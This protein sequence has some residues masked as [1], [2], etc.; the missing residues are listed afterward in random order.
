MTK[1]ER[2][3]ARKTYDERNYELMV[4]LWKEELESIPRWNRKENDGFTTIPRWLPIINRIMDKL[5][6]G[7]PISSTYLSLWFRV[8]DEGFIHIKD[9]KQMAIESGFDSERNISTWKTRMRELEKF[10]FINS[11]TGV[12]GEFQYVLIVNPLNVIEN[13]DNIAEY[14]SLPKS[15]K[16]IIS[17]YKINLQ[18]RMSEV[19]A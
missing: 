3:K 19:G 2:A 18:E 11:I 1:K 6:Q 17:Q 7:K 4:S 9:E 13:L 16:E 8:N 15:I 14:S 12:K 5:S 10:G